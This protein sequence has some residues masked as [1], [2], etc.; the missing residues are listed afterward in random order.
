VAVD[1]RSSERL[2]FNPAAGSSLPFKPLSRSGPGASR[3]PGV[4]LNPAALVS[5]LEAAS[6]IPGVSRQLIAMW[7]RNNKL[8][9]AG[10][11]GR[12]PLYRWG[13][14]IAVEQ[15]TR[16]SKHSTRHR[17]GPALPGTQLLAA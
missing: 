17:R 4:D 15:A 16:A 13:D 2:T 11:R 14:I 9:P 8:K 10:K 5:A 7:R 6:Q 1:G 12:S 3:V